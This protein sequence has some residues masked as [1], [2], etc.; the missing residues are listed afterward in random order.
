MTS[1]FSID[2][3]DQV[4][5]LARLTKLQRW[6]LYGTFAVLPGLVVMTWFGWWAALGFEVLASRPQQ[7]LFDTLNL[8]A[9]LPWTKP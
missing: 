1:R 8:A 9:A 7:R 5:A 6:A 2:K 4:V 3:N